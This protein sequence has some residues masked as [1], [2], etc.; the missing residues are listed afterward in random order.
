VRPFR[1]LGLKCLAFV[2]ALSLWVLVSGEEESVRVFTV[3]IDYSFA[4]D[5]V[6]ASETPGSAEVRLRGSEAVLRRLTS[7][8]LSVALDLGGR[9]PGGRTVQLLT[10]RMVRSV[11][12]GAA[13]EQIVP[14]RITV[15]VE[16]KVPRSVAVSPRFEGSPPPG[17][18][19][20]G[21]QAEPAHVTI[22]GPESE[23]S[24]VG[25]VHTDPIP[26]DSR[27]ISFQTPVAVSL[28]EPRI[29]LVGPR[30]VT[31][32]VHIEEEPRK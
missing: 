31:V 17:Y 1:N 32:S 11:P 7:D 4:P 30:T 9:P 13:V 3:P 22:E 20:L 5:R 25:S 14:E 19:L 29:S 23:V 2:I 16:R 10:P 28:D 24:R 15:T 27:R 18:R 12:S 26:L 6:P 21:S 8:A